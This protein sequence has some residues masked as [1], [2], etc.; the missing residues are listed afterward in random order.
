[1]VKKVAKKTKPKVQPAKKRA[2]KKDVAFRAAELVALQRKFI[3]DKGKV[4]T[5]AQLVKFS[6]MP[7]GAV[8]LWRVK[9]PKPVLPN[10][11]IS[12]A[13]KRARA[14]GRVLLPAEHRYYHLITLAK[15]DNVYIAQNTFIK[16]L[17]ISGETL[18]KKQA[19]GLYSDMDHQGNIALKKAIKQFILSKSGS[20][21][22]QSKE[23]FERRL[24]ELKVQEIEGRLISRSLMKILLTEMARNSGSITDAMTETISKRLPLSL[25]KDDRATIELVV[26]GAVKNLKQ[27]L[28]A[29]PDLPNHALFEEEIETDE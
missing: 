12:Q 20:P 17:G 22:Q 3:K 25:S 6:G 15:D 23:Q 7:L 2:G 26:R 16:W 24:L 9:N 18:L 13:Q 4:P 27:K 19:A 5:V 28:Q 8:N 21:V 10:E 14:E 11:T 29:L 1:M